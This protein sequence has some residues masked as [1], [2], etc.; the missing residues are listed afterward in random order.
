MRNARLDA[1]I[2]TFR[3]HTYTHQHPSPAPPP[4]THRQT[5]T[6]HPVSTQQSTFRGRTM[7]K[8]DHNLGQEESVKGARSTA[9]SACH[10]LTLA[11]TPLIRRSFPPRRPGALRLPGSHRPQCERSM[12]ANRVY[13]PSSTP[14]LL[15]YPHILTLFTQCTHVYTLS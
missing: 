2:H 3:L 6:L 1:C 8:G 7:A 4:P 12:R 15:S 9:S 11:R 10:V 13:T 5:H 14:R